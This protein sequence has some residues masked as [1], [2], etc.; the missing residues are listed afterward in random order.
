MEGYTA[1]LELLSNG[2]CATVCSPQHGVNGFPDSRSGY[3]DTI[4]EAIANCEWGSFVDNKEWDRLT[5][6]EVYS[7]C[8]LL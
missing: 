6:Q 2:F 1:G 4:N 7:D 5:M 8:K 3:G